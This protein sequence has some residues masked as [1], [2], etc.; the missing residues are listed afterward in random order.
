MIQVADT[1][2]APFIEYLTQGVLP[3][4][5]NKVGTLQGQAARYILV[6]GILYRRGYSMPLLRC[7]LKE[8][9]K[10]LMKEVHGGFCGDHAGEKSLSK[11]I[12]RQG[13]FWPMMNEDLMEFVRR[14]DKCQRFSKIPRVAPNELKQ[15]Q[16]P[17]PCAVW[18][19]DLIRS[20]PI[21]KGGV[22]CVIVAIDYFTKWA[23]AEPL[24]TITAKK[25]LDFVIKNIVCHY[26]LPRKISRIT[27]PNLIVIYS[28]IF[29]NGME[30]SRYFLQSLI[31]KKMD[32]LKQSTKC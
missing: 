11:K 24:A 4:N 23:E 10:E 8:K 12:L 1:W 6:D 19:I 22:K 2:M 17:W 27:T 5:I 14:C 32:K 16:S 26:G 31:P 30:L 13:Y 21:G 18:G 15:M 7:I 29:A 28:R 9:A 20:L 3:T 25:V